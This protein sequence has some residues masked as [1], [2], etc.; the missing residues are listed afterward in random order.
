MLIPKCRVLGPL[1]EAFGDVRVELRRLGVQEGVDPLNLS[2][3]NEFN[4]SQQT[5]VLVFDELR[6]VVSLPFHVH[7]L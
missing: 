6:V 4:I 5:A 3:A 7:R 1:L 2:F